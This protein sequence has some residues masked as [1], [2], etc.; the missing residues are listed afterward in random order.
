MFWG[1]AGQ[2]G[3]GG[4]RGMGRGGTEQRRISRLGG[5][6]RAWRHAWGGG[7]PPPQC[8]TG[9]AGGTCAPGPVCREIP[10]CPVL[11][12][13]FSAQKSTALGMAVPGTALVVF[14]AGNGPAHNRL[15]AAPCLP[16]CRWRHK[17]AC[18]QKYPGRCVLPACRCCHSRSGRRKNSPCCVLPACRWR[19][20][21]PVP[22]RDRDGCFR[23]CGHARHNGWSAQKS[24][25]GW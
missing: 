1:T 21:A 12:R 17:T 16:A 22:P 10:F 3:A 2:A 14:Q 7:L 23:S 11:C 8:S 15:A 5:A 18:C 6:P 25:C 19:H 9:L 13:R 4:F 20:R 24:L